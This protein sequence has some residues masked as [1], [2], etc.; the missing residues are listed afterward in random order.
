MARARWGKKRTKSREGKIETM[1]MI[2]GSV[3]PKV[4]CMAIYLQEIRELDWRDH[5]G[6]A[7]TS[8]YYWISSSCL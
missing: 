4:F 3:A 5:R 1:K 2:A 6:Q 8:S 7:G